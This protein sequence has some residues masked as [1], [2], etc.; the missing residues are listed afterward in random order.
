MIDG[1]LPKEKKRMI[2][3]IDEFITTADKSYLNG[4]AERLSV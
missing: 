3:V 1:F 4:I 2:E